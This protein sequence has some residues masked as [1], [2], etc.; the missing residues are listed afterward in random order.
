MLDMPNNRK[1]EILTKLRNVSQTGF[2][3]E[4]LV[5]EIIFLEDQLFELK[6]L[7][8]INVDEKNTKKQKKT[9]AFQQYIALLQQYNNCVKTMCS[10]LTTVQEKEGSALREYFEM[11][12]KKLE[13]Y[14]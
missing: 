6:K 14:E 10:N 12:K 1:V 2:I 9:A 7:P 3:L 8:F 4:P 11:R 13:R 5:D